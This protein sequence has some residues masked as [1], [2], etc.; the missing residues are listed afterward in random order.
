MLEI[1]LKIE[2][3]RQKTR[4]EMV[5]EKIVKKFKKRFKQLKKLKEIGGGLVEG[6]IKGG[7]F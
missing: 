1:R 6:L 4:Y 3:C 2:V 7:V 5:C